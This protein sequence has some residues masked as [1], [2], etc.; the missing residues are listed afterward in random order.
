MYTLRSNIHKR[1]IACIGYSPGEVL[2]V[3]GT[4]FFFFFLNTVLYHACILQL[5]M[6]TQQSQADQRGLGY[7][8][9]LKEAMPRGNKQYYKVV[10]R[11]ADLGE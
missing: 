8:Y 11:G 4:L 10:G 5:E 3:A 7:I 1:T 9:I 6:A 2:H